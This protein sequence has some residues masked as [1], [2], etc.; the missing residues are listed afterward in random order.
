VVPSPPSS[1]PGVLGVKGC[2]R[3]ALAAARGLAGWP[4]GGVATGSASPKQ[5]VETAR[6]G[7]NLTSGRPDAPHEVATNLI[8]ATV[9]INCPYTVES[10]AV[11]GV[12][13]QAPR[14]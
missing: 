12:A 10:R 4:C 9:P 2:A 8:V 1:M 13:R 7:Q 5:G 11:G 6:S 14:S 3:S